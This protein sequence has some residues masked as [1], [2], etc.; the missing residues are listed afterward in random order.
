[1]NAP[2]PG[3]YVVLY[4]WRIKPGH[5]K[6]FAAAWAEVTERLLDA[7]SLGS[8]L[9]R[10]DDGCWYGYAQWPS[11]E[12]RAAAFAKNLA[13]GASAAMQAA[14]AET[15]PSVELTPVADYLQ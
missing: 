2:G 3:Y 6:A 4:R 9:H 8:R 15:L 7:G 14:I 11:A 12:V 13:P 1:M 10:G 5:E